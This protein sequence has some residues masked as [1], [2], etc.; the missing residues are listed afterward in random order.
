MKKVTVKINTVSPREEV[1]NQLLNETWVEVIS[2]VDRENA[3]IASM[4]E[5]DIDPFT[6]TFDATI[7][8]L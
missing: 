7:T 4:M 2:L 1:I 5:Y 3:F 6:E 8:K